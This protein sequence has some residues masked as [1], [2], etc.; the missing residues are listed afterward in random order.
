[1]LLSAFMGSC[2][3]PWR[4]VHRQAYR[5][6]PAPLLWLDHVR[7]RESQYRGITVARLFA[8]LSTGILE[9]EGFRS[10]LDFELVSKAR[11]FPCITS[12]TNK[13]T[14]DEAHFSYEGYAGPDPN[15]NKAV[16][17]EGNQETVIKFTEAYNGTAH[18]PLAARGLMPPLCPCDR[19]IFS[20]F[21]ILVINYVDG[22]QLFRKNS[23]MTPGEVL[24]KVSGALEVL[25]ANNLVLGDLRSP[26]VFI[27]ESKPTPRLICGFRLVW[28]GRRRG[29]S[30]GHQS[31]RC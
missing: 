20:N 31:C 16:G 12:F 7:T 13:S 3:C 9:L 6:T 21:T 1:M 8:A 5:P 2:L 11:V 19:S 24:N 14:K 30:S 29:V 22:E 26:N 23:Y 18:F 15:D 28:K 17:T 27:T 10:Y 25:H 4:G